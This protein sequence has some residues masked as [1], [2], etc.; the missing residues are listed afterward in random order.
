MK[1]QMLQREILELDLRGVEI[2][3]IKQINTER[4]QSQMKRALPVKERPFFA[5]MQSICDVWVDD[6]IFVVFRSPVL[7]PGSQFFLAKL[8]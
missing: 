5:S 3:T 4:E 7:P 2:P 6:V 1:V 8:R